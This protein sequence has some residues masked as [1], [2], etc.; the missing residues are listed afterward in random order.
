[1]RRRRLE[2]AEQFTSCSR[3]RVHA[4]ARSAGAAASSHPPASGRQPQTRRSELGSSHTAALPDPCGLKEGDRP[5]DGRVREEAWFAC[6]A[7]SPSPAVLLALRDR[8]SAFSNSP[9]DPIQPSACQRRKSARLPFSPGAPLHPLQARHPPA[10]WHPSRPL[11]GQPCRAPPN[12]RHPCRRRRTP[13]AA[14]GAR[15]WGRYLA[16]CWA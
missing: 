11:T 3:E 7:L 14:S 9:H 10:P 4:S 15:T 6:S 12:T 5:G 13:P 2:A 16:R 1:M 8:N